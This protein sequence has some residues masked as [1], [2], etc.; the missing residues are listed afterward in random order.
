MPVNST[1]GVGAYSAIAKLTGSASGMAKTATPA[2]G[3][4]EFRDIVESVLSNVM[5][6]GDAMQTQAANLANGKANTLDLVTTVTKT[7]LAV[8]TLVTV[9]DRVI[10]AYQDI[11][12]MPI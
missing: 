1:V 10:T 8:E 2:Q 6:S 9:R 4:T 11:L 5:K 3:G 7:E 12:N